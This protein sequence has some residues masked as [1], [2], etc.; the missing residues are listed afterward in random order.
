MTKKK[1]KK[2]LNKVKKDKVSL[3][4]LQF[5]DFLGNLKS[6]TIST[7]ELPTALQSGTWF[8]GSSVEGFARIHESDMRLFPDPQTYALIPWHSENNGRVA[9]FICDIC[10]PNGQPFAGDPRYLLKKTIL[11]AKKTGFDFFVGPELE[12]FLFK[13]NE[14][15][16]IK[17]Y[18]SGNNSYFLFSLDETYKI[19][20]EMIEALET[21]GIEVEMSHCEVA[22][23]QH[24]IDFRYDRALKTADN[25]I[26]LKYALKAI[27]QKHGFYA[28]FM[29]KP[30]FGVNGSG[31]HVHQSFFKRNK[32]LFLES[33]INT[34]YQKLLIPF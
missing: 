15:G 18:S 12:F 2:V 23:N 31:M 9:R 5:T 1:I 4:E 16:K 13:K 26:T 32:T 24:E 34:V 14:Q 19:K 30:I 11:E 25:T 7:R 33:Q 10:L 20:R 6:V 28:S 3:V 8:D 27:G 22:N 21:M 29:P 17:V